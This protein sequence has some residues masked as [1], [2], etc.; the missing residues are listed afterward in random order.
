MVEETG[1]GL[2]SDIKVIPRISMK[3]IKYE[4]WKT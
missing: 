2:E 3:Y 4:K 1:I